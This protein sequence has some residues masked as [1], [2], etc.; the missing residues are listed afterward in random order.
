MKTEEIEAKL[1]ERKTVHQ[2]LTALG[3]PSEEMG[4]P[5]SLLRRLRITLD[6][7]AGMKKRLEEAHEAMNRIYHSTSCT[8]YQ[9]EI[10]NEILPDGTD[11]PCKSDDADDMCE[12][13]DCW[14]ATRANC[15]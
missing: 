13:C 11:N 15:S 8:T 14:K 6:Q 2:W 1:S 7:Y 9:M 3:V 5:I 12:Q 10:I 4:K